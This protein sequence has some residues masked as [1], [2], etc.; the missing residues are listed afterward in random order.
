M[1]YWDVVSQIIQNE[2]SFNYAA[3]VILSIFLPALPQFE[4][5]GEVCVHAG[6][7]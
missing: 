6:H 2:V 4:Q 1:K 5:I 3:S 7:A